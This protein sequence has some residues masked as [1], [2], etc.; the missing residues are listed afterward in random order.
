MLFHMPQ[1]LYSY[2]FSPEK[3]PTPQKFVCK[4]YLYSQLVQTGKNASVMQVSR[5]TNY[6]TLIQKNMLYNNN[7][8][9][10]K[11]HNT[12]MNLKS[13]ERFQR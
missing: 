3:S 1:Q 9:N 11:L 8:C 2:I 12:W 10:I 6:G 4:L 13:S 7:K 5:I